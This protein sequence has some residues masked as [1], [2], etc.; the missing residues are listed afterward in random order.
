M[1]RQPSVKTKLAASDDPTVMPV[2]KSDLI[3]ANK[4]PSLTTAIK[5][6]YIRYVVYIFNVRE[7]KNIYTNFN[8]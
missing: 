6:D 3:L 1:R 8:N 7:S 2:I 5:K 4:I